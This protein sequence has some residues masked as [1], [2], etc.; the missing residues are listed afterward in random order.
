MIEILGVKLTYD[1]IAWIA[2]FVASEIIG[3]SKLKENSVASLAKTM[4][5]RMKPSRK[6]DDKVAEVRKATQL[7]RET[8]RRLGD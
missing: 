3:S 5:D 1:T 7:L 8:L 4:I 6:E 2:A